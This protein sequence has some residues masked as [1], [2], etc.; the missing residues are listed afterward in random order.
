M[1]KCKKT[2]VIV[3]MQYSSSN[4]S[5]FLK[6]YLTY[7]SLTKVE[8][9]N[10]EN[11]IKTHNFS[12][13]SNMRKIIRTYIQNLTYTYQM[14]FYFSSFIYLPTHLNVPFSIKLSIL[15]KIT[16]SMSEVEIIFSIIVLST[17]ISVKVSEALQ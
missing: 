4:F 8:I 16:S 1:H 12:L 2:K 14:Y 7:S 6:I 3:A 5:S 15:Y 17:S 10:S 13:I 11:N 9:I